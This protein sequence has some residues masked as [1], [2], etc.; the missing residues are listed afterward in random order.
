MGHILSTILCMITKLGVVS[1]S[2]LFMSFISK[3]P[4]LNT[5]L[6]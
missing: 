5:Q 3:H 4:S 1:L 6:T 2:N